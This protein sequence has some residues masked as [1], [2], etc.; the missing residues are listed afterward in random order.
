MTRVESEMQA[1]IRIRSPVRFPYEP[2]ISSP[3]ENK[4]YTYSFRMAEVGLT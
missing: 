3:C 4:E 1:S 2:Y